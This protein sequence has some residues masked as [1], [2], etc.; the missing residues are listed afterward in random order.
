MSRYKLDADGCANLNALAKQIRICTAGSM[1]AGVALL[2]KIRTLSGSLGIY[3]DDILSVIGQCMSTLRK[4]QGALEGLAAAVDAKAEQMED[5]LSL[6][7]DGGDEKIS[8]FRIAGGGGGDPEKFSD[9]QLPAIKTQEESERWKAGCR[10]NSEVIRNIRESLIARGIPEGPW[11]TAVLSRRKD[12]M[13]RQLANDIGFEYGKCAKQKIDDF[14]GDFQHLYDRL[15]TEYKMGQWSRIPGGETF[16]ASLAATN[17][18]NARGKEWQYNC[19]RCVP[20]Y[21]MRRRGYDVTAAPKTAFGDYLSHHPFAVWENPDVHQCGGDGRHEICAMMA[22]WGEGARA[23]ITVTWD[24]TN[25]GHTFVAEQVGG[26]TVFYDPQTNRRDA[27]GYFQL[28]ESG[29]VRICR[30]DNLVPSKMM[31]ECCREVK[32]HA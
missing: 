21:E 29:S 15:E 32:N 2:T 18:N 20:C 27:S 22:G 26:K 17:P 5:I 28:V 7:A 30:V 10:D 14:D 25:I 16:S 24:K 11:L 1:Q 13:M 8:A 19:Q 23:Q 31:L 9:L 12:L 6:A 3:E 4:N